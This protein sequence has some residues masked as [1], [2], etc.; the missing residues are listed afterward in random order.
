MHLER[1]LFLRRSSARGIS[2][3]ELMAAVVI[4]GI[5][6]TVAVVGYRRWTRSARVAEA[7]NIITGIAAA[8]EAYKGETGAYLNVSG[9]LDNLYP[10]KAPGS[11]KTEWGGPCDT[12]LQPWSS[13]SFQPHGAVMY[14]YATVASNSAVPSAPPDPGGGSSSGGGGGPLGFGKGGGGGSDPGA[15][16]PGP[17][18][19]GPPVYS[20]DPTGP[21]YTVVGKG[22][23]DGDGVSTTV[24]FYSE[25]RVM[26]VQNE[27]E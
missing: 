26:I 12:C 24:L 17:G 5:L 4:V 22:D 25:T 11:F 7:N 13:L 2:L 1:R 27:G 18:G 23:S 6:A 20:P 21:F 14:G 16:G 19:D 3:I 8:Q 10:A 15:I 9:S